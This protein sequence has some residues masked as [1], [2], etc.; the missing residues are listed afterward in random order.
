M[1]NVQSNLF[2]RPD[3]FFGVCE[4]L[5]EDLGFHPN[6]LRVALAGLLFWNPPAAIGVYA[7]LGLLVALT[8]WLVPVPRPA[9][10]PAEPIAV[11][12]QDAPASEPLRANDQADP[13]ALAA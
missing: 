9:A 4:G 7:A 1:Q 6:L 13:V 5:G 10:L 3:T 12:S 8:R 11:P 2:T